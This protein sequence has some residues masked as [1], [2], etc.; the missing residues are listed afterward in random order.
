MLRIVWGGCGWWAAPTRVA[1]YRVVPA[2]RLPFRDV[3]GASRPGFGTGWALIAASAHPSR[4]AVARCCSGC[5]VRC[6]GEPTRAAANCAGLFGVR[7]SSGLRGAF[8]L[9]PG[10]RLGARYANLIFGPAG[11]HWPMAAGC[12]LSRS[13]DVGVGAARRLWQLRVRAESPVVL[14]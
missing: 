8:R 4:G 2:R 13:G 1:D 5:R 14:D 3:L 11:G 6:G 12:R 9:G 7:K 10:R